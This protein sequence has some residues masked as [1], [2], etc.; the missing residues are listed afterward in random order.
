MGSTVNRR[1][2]GRV[3]LVTGA[4]QGIGRAI[5][6]RLA[7]EGAAV[8]VNDLRPEA[9]DAVVDAITA[10]G[11]QAVAAPGDVGREETASR[12]VEVATATFGTLD[13]LVNNAGITR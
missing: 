4:A 11:G 3:A 10:Q 13:V 12:L 1:F 8:V 7:A 2:E 5:V 6:D 9:C